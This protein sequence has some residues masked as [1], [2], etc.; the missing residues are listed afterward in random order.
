MINKENILITARKVSKLIAWVFIIDSRS[1][2]Y[3]GELKR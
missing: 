1:E 3:F 2:T